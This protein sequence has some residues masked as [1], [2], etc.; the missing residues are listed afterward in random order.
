MDHARALGTIVTT[1]DLPF[2]H[3]NFYARRECDAKSA[4][5]WQS[6]FG[7]DL[8]EDPSLNIGM[9][10]AR[11]DTLRTFC[12]TWQ[13]ANLRWL[14][15]EP[16]H[17]AFSDICVDQLTFSALA[18]TMDTVEAIALPPV[19]NM[20]RLLWTLMPEK[21]PDVLA[22]HLTG[23]VKPWQPAGR[24][25]PITDMWKR[26]AQALENGAKP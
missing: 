17:N 21:I 18:T 23:P 3:C 10:A 5:F 15:D 11:A 7:R 19:Y 20:T 8:R 22:V 9:L 12:P 13:R 26:T 2:G 1:Q 16:F 6:W 14:T 24:I 25:H 4:E